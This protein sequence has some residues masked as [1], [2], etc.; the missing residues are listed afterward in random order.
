M[1]EKKDDAAGR[2]P[3]D[4]RDQPRPHRHRWFD[5]RA[6]FLTGLVVAAPITITIFLTYTFITVVDDWVDRLLPDRYNPSS[7]IPFTVPGLGVI[8]VFL[9]LV[10]LGAF[11]ANVFGRTLIR[12]GESLLNAMPVIR[13]VYMTLKQIF[14]TVVSQNTQSFNQV[15]LVEYPR[16][17]IWAIAFVTTSTRG[18]IVTRVR[19][20]GQEDLVSLFLPTTPNPTS[21]FLLF[22]P[23]R[24]LIMLDMSVEEGAKLVISGGLVSPEVEKPGNGRPQNGR[25]AKDNGVPTQAGAGRDTRAL[26]RKSEGPSDGAEALTMTVAPN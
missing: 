10:L 12:I 23:R 21:G 24:D 11:T 8:L 16:R 4:D 18:E 26:D 13:T 7:Y 5:I 14:E 6:Y 3:G 20:R 2:L 17:G 25:S 1:S 19:E 22:A 15:A 9:V